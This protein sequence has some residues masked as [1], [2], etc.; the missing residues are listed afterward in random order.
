MIY[1]TYES[2]GHVNWPDENG[3]HVG[4]ARERELGPE[5]TEGEPFTLLY[6]TLLY[7][8]LIWGVGVGVSEL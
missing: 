6:F 3:G 4:I 2:D 5:E 1:G 8:N 7:F